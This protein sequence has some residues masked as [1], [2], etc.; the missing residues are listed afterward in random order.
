[1]SECKLCGSDDTEFYRAEDGDEHDVIHCYACGHDTVV[2][3]NAYRANG[4]NS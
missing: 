1:M 4:G 3:P 2:G